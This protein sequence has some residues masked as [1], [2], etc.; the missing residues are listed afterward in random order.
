MTNSEWPVVSELLAEIDDDIRTELANK[1]DVKDVAPEAF[2]AKQLPL[3]QRLWHRLED[4]VAVV[5]DLKGSTRLSTGNEHA[6]STATVYEAATDNAV[7]VFN[8]FSA[9]F[10]QIQ[11]DGVLALFWGENRF[12]RAIC[13]GI[14]VKSFGASLKDK[15]F[16]KWGI[17]TGY[18][19]GIASGRVL[20]K[21]L[22][23]PRNL[24]EQEP[25]WAG[26]PVNFATKAAQ[27]ADVNELIVTAS[28]WAEVEDIDYLVV[29]CGHNDGKPSTKAGLWRGVQIE[30]I[31][32][33]DESKGQ[34]LEA[35]WC[36][37]CGDEFCSK[38][39]AGEKSRSD[40][41]MAAQESRQKALAFFGNSLANVRSRKPKNR[42]PR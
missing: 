9:D 34:L 40:S 25:V 22:G 39:L 12:E 35:T 24:D 42:G 16:D 31:A 13:A 27:H 36:E 10:I 1:P 18:K 29:S 14:T 8:K 3:G 21:R 41:A 23:T 11:G 30:N 26:K 38:I 6:A 20:A 32:H 4:V 28:V 5:V 2:D 33:E 17:E 15:V 37:H 7:K 19:V